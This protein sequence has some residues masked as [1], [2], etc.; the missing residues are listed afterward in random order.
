MCGCSIALVVSNSLRSYGLYP[1]KLLCLWDS[2][3]RILGLLCPSPGDLPHPE[4]KS[5]SPV[6]LALQADSLP[7]KPPGKSHQ[8]K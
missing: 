5:M 7:I 6:S 1:A 3:A 2:Q 8:S 4:I